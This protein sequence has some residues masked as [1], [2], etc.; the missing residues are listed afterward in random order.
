MLDMGFEVD[1]GDII[2][3]FNMPADHQTAMFSAT[4]PTELEMMAAEVLID[5]VSLTVDDNEN[6]WNVPL[7]REPPMHPIDIFVDELSVTWNVEDDLIPQFNQSANDS[8][9]DS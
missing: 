4:L 6:S 7:P 1:V 2:S 9:Y 3:C 5:H 8:G